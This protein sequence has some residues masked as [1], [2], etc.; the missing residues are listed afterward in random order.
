[1]NSNSCFL[2]FRALNRHYRRCP[3]ISSP[4]KASRHGKRWTEIAE[5]KFLKA[6]NGEDVDQEGDGN[7]GGG[8]GDGG[9]REED[10]GQPV[11]HQVADV[12]PP[13]F[14]RDIIQKISDS[15]ADG[16]KTA[17]TDPLIVE[18]GMLEYI[19]DSDVS[20]YSQVRKKMRMLGRLVDG[21]RSYIRERTTLD[22]REE[23]AS[24]L[25]LSKILSGKDY[26]MIIWAV[27][28]VAGG[29][30]SSRSWRGF[31]KPNNAVKATEALKI[32]I[33]FYGLHG[34]ADSSLFWERLVNGKHGLVGCRRFQAGDV[35]CSS[36]NHFFFS[37][38]GRTWKRHIA[39]H[40]KS[41]KKSLKESHSKKRTGAFRLPWVAD[42]IEMHERLRLLID[43]AVVSFRNFPTPQG[44]DDLAGLVLA[45]LTL[46]NI[47]R[48]GDVQY[49]TVQNHETGL[50]LGRDER[51]NA[52]VWVQL[53]EEEQRLAE[54]TAMT[55][56]K[57]KNNT[58]VPVFL[59]PFELAAIDLL[60]EKRHHYV[61]EGNP[62]LFAAK[63]PGKGFKSGTTMIRKWREKIAAFEPGCMREP[64]QLTAGS[65]R[66]LFCT[67][68]NLSGLSELEKR[69]LLVVVDHSKRTDA[70]HYLQNNNYRMMGRVPRILE[71]FRTNGMLA[72]RNLS[73]TEA[74]DGNGDETGKKRERDARRAV[75]ANLLFFFDRDKQMT[76]DR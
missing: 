36:N 16:S 30:S 28:T 32:A 62:Y 75:V 9:G 44:Y 31:V 40:I 29:V 37:V 56:L 63:K 58:S 35:P 47:R 39:A 67:T 60:L 46:F 74:S 19:E 64:E 50:L 14:E 57:T 54:E 48:V 59:R 70:E 1:M 15:E 3:G 24:A 43:Q 55:R 2:L 41:G 76:S 20:H 71:A 27:T 25:D 69:E 6:V 38:S 10:E 13:N 52:D 42:V 21:C 4:S 53:D 34:G 17:K 72:R 49:Y 68:L 12:P 66:K 73:A 23:R 61:A 5:G 51:K 18:I 65:I 26:R 45:S 8:G 7:R 22:D 33:D 11:H